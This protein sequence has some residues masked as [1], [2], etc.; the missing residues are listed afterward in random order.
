MENKKILRVYDSGAKRYEEVMKEYWHIP[1][2]PFIASL[3]F[4]RG[5]RILE[6]AVGT[7]LNLPY[8]PIGTHILGIDI[9]KRMLGEA[10]KKQV[11][12]NIELEEGDIHSLRFPDSYFDSAVSTFTLC[13]VEN[14]K[15]ALQ[16]IIRV[17][18]SGSKI[19]LLD[20]CKSRNPSVTKWQELIHYHASNIGFPK[21]VIVWDSLM[22]YDK[23]IYHSN[24]PIEVESDERIESEN[25][26]S[27]GCKIILRN[28][29]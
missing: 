14:P 25:P 29:K 26:F 10:R 17:T 28:R 23:L 8:Y 3:G 6:S 9:S 12:A 20:Y 4:K 11:L 24:L 18:K 16:E 19:T 22:D 2:E 27:T 15:K 1:R 7:G 13:V 21:D 5:E